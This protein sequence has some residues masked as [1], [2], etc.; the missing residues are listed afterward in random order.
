M[1]NI[2][3]PQWTSADERPDAGTDWLAAPLTQL[4]RFIVRAYHEP[5][6]R[7]LPRLQARAREVE[8]AEWPQVLGAVREHLDALARDVPAHLDYEEQ[9]LFPA[10]DALARGDRGPFRTEESRLPELERQHDAFG[11]RLKH[12]ARLTAWFTAPVGAGRAAHALCA[13]LSSLME[14]TYVHVHLER[15]VLLARAVDVSRRGHAG[16][17]DVTNGVQ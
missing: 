13:E 10:I 6:R 12:L 4:T 1:P 8:L 5:L 16:A 15:N 11:M 7:D 9:Q 17:A 3:P 14:A 2:P